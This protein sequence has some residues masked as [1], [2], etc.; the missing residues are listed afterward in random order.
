METYEGI[1]R[2]YDNTH[3]VTAGGEH[4]KGYWV[5]LGGGKPLWVDLSAIQNPKILVGQRVSVSGDKWTQSGVESKKNI[6]T[7]TKLVSVFS[8]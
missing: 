8:T 5:D 4:Y 1:L 3:M 2:W 6:L 7:V